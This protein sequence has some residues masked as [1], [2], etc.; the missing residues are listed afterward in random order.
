MIK[1]VN[2]FNYCS[3]TFFFL[4]KHYNDK[5]KLIEKTIYYQNIQNLGCTKQY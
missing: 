4:C 3:I 2:D 5:K 1:K